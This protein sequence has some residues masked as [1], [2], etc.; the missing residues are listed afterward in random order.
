VFGGVLA[1][2]GTSGGTGG[3][4]VKVGGGTLIL[5]GADTYTG[6]TNINAG[7]LDV[8]GSL[9]STVFVNAGGTLMGNGFIGGLVV[10]PGATVAPGNSIG[11][12]T[13]NGNV[14]FLPGSF[15]QVE[16]NAAGQSDKILASGAAALSGGTVQV[17]A[18]NQAYARQTRYT[19]LTAN[20]GVTGTFAGVT[21]NLAFLTPTLSY[22]PD[23]VFLTLNRN[24]ITF[25]S[26]AQTPNQAPSLAPWI[27]ARRLAR[28]CRPSSI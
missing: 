27:A 7:I 21:S 17:L 20:G 10:R 15:Y 2:G 19:I 4:L 5:S 1:D 11:T 3:S 13:V 8:N 9:V 28:S 22:D 26:V 24:D 23:D 18:E 12:L 14:T 16:A 25:A 6:P